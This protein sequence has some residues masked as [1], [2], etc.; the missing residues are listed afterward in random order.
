M[1]RF[2][3]FHLVRIGVCIHSSSACTRHT[4]VT[5]HN[6]RNHAN[7]IGSQ[8]THRLGIRIPRSKSQDRIV[9]RAEGFRERL[10]LGSTQETKPNP[11]RF[12]TLLKRADCNMTRTQ[13]RTTPATKASDSLVGIGVC[14][15]SRVG[16]VRS[17]KS[18]ENKRYDICARIHVTQCLLS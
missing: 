12:Q 2:P 11:R 4:I 7:G 13:H 3:S 16:P 8:P 14:N 1:S 18:V 9:L 6:D 5:S 10:G 17:Q 15:A